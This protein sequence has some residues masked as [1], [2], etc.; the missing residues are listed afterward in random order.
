[1][2]S[3]IKEVEIVIKPDWV[4]WDEIKQCLVDAHSVNRSKGI[5]MNHYQWSIEKIKEYIGQNGVMIVALDGKKVVGTAAIIEKKGKYWFVNGRFAYFGFASV[6][7]GYSGKGIFKKLNHA[8]EMIAQSQGY[9]VFVTD[10]HEKNENRIHLA[11]RGGY[12]FVK[13][14]SVK[15]DGHHNVMMAKWPTGCP[16]P[17]IYCNFCFY[18]SYLRVHLSVLLRR[19]SI[20]FR[21]PLKVKNR[22]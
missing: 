15:S 7:P 22:K 14:F 2:N 4:S 9:E 8:R 18:Y 11:N 19:I 13:Y 10:T 21:C 16:Y 5:N 6:L 3:E 20:K 12:Y 1:M 17:K